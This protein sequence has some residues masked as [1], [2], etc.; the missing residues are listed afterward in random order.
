MNKHRRE[1]IVGPKVDSSHTKISCK[2]CE[3]YS[4]GLFCVFS[5]FMSVR[6]QM[7]GDLQLFY[8]KGVIMIENNA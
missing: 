4:T 3:V 6:S 2:A 5:L 7:G 1:T 8:H